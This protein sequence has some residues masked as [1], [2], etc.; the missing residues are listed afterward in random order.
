MATRGYFLLSKTSKRGVSI[1]RVV[2]VVLGGA[3]AWIALSSSQAGAITLVDQESD[4][5]NTGVAVSNTG[6]NSATGNSSDST[7]ST[8][9]TATANNNGD[10]GVAVNTA[11]SSNNSSGSA[12][13]DTGD[14]NSVGNQSTTSSTQVADG[15]DGLAVID[16][17]S[18]TD[19]TGVA[20]ANTGINLAVGNNSDNTT[21]VDQTAKANNNGGDGIA[22]NTANA[23][24]NSTGS[25]SITTG[26]ANALGNSSS[27]QVVQVADADG[28][29]LFI[30]DQEQDTDNF[31]LALANSGINLAVG[32]DSVN[33]STGVSQSSTANGN[34][35]DGVAVNDTSAANNST[36]SATVATG[37]ARAL[38]NQ[39]QDSTT[40]V[41]DGDGVNATRAG[42]D[43]A[44]AVVLLL[45]FLLLGAPARRLATR[46]Y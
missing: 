33:D 19:N 35:G 28:D 27:T 9:Q 12:S 37:N 40:Q 38:G 21:S 30:V 41:I 39:S 34:A 31:G 4:T 7:A 6:V 36:G 15:G 22:V 8:E 23:S 46:R 3:A 11:N 20:V 1:L 17:E 29:S 26:D 5:D 25:A 2:A 44:T 45:A 14:A 10:D 42:A 43:P 32:N 18:D 24:N 13:I 16:Q